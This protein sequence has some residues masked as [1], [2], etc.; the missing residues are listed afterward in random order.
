MGK[1]IKIVTLFDSESERSIESLTQK[2]N[3]INQLRDIVH[4]LINEELINSKKIYGKRVL[5]KP[6]W[7]YHDLMP[8]DEICLR[9]HNNLLIVVLELI[10]ESK[11][12]QVTI[13]DA[14]VQGC[15]WDKILTTTLRSQLVVIANKY[16]VP[17]YIKDFRRKTFSPKRNNPVHE[18]NPITDYV[19]FDLGSESF[20]EPISS[21][22][23]N[24]FRVTCYNPD[25]L[26]ESHQKGTHK[27]CISKELFNN[28]LIISLPKIKTHQKTGITGALKNLVGINGDKDFLPHHRI[29]GTERGGDCYPGKNILRYWSELSID[30]ANRKQGNMMYR[31]WSIISALCW[32]LSNPKELHHISAAWYGNDTTWRMVLDLNKIAIYGKINGMISYFPQRE[33]LTIGDGIIGGQGD[34]P[35]HPDPLPLG[36]LSFSNDSGLHDYII[37]LLMKFNSNKI[38]LIK[39][40]LHSNCLQNENVS[41][42]VNNEI[43]YFNQICEFGIDTIPPPGWTGY[44]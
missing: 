27:Y 37:T 42:I 23:K 13:G 40:G 43:M 17:V 35:L 14:P 21:F 10:L 20:L 5:I 41:I 2:Y 22:E 39:N 33:I 16:K 6:N 7:V 11:P 15:N 28:D 25:R 31:F 18:I 30:E 4:E 24:V 8:Q 26:A 34:G 9:T 1:F 38:S 36:I 32:K 12:S 3:D 19:I 44:L 29:G